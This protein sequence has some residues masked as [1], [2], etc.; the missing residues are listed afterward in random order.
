MSVLWIWVL[1]C[2][3]PVQENRNKIMKSPHKKKEDNCWSIF[4]WEHVHCTYTPTHTHTPILLLKKATNTEYK[5][6]NSSSH[7]WLKWTCLSAGSWLYLMTQDK[8]VKAVW[9]LFDMDGCRVKGFWAL[10]KPHE[11]CR[12]SAACLTCHHESLWQHKVVSIQIEQTNLFCKSWF[13]RETTKHGEHNRHILNCKIS[14]PQ[15]E[16]KMS[17]QI[18][19]EKINRIVQRM[20]YTPCSSV[21]G[22]IRNFTWVTT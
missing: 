4:L 11:P 14:Q 21:S 19:D 18:N 10:L 22:T 16:H 8:M 9:K 15:Q 1:I 20:M 13:F 2:H 17:L 3:Q 7:H 5:S 6:V 12:T